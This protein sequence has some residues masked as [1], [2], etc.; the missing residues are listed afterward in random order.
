MRTHLSDP[1]AIDADSAGRQYAISVVGGFV[2]VTMGQLRWSCFD[3]AAAAAVASAQSRLHGGSPAAEPE[4]LAAGD[5]I[6]GRGDGAGDVGTTLRCK[7]T[8]TCQCDFDEQ[9]TVLCREVL[10]N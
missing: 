6:G 9:C 10:R 5:G 3:E 8:A 2:Y 4:S 1:S 7:N